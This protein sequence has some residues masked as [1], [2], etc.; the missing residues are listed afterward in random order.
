MS[1]TPVLAVGRRALLQTLVGG[2]GLG[3]ALPS[4]GES[5]PM[6]EHLH[7]QARVSAADAK[8]KTAAWKPA[9]L[10][11]HQVETVTILAE[12][13]VPGSTKAKS[14]QFIDAL[15]SV[16]TEQRQR[17]FLQALGAFEGMA[18]AHAQK[19]WKSLTEADR[20]TLLT[21]A[22]T[23]E[24]GVRRSGRTWRRASRFRR[25]RGHAAGGTGDHDS[26]S[27]R[28]PQGLDLRRVLL[29]RDGH[30]RAGVDRQRL[31][32]EVHRVPTRGLALRGRRL[33]MPRGAL[34]RRTLAPRSSLRGQPP[35]ASPAAA[36]VFTNVT[37]AAGITFTHVNGAFGKKY[38]P[39]TMGSGVAFLDVD[40]DG[41]QDLF[42]VN[43]KSWPGQTAFDDRR[44][45]SIATTATARS[46]TSRNKRGSRSRCTAS[47][48]PPRISTTTATSIC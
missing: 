17:R 21:K 7:D 20:T 10:D 30:A 22:S 41:Y 31:L 6:H 3:L 39:E 19:P 46:P 45:R 23:A 1:D 14:A 13:I 4:L 26:R 43:G 29:V 12:Q 16:D 40:G 35:A 42:F 36:V 9:F 32:R 44:R 48:R 25:W 34:S 2:A 27:V 5:H 15:L 18:I 8:A 33:A 28:S 37:A 38:L 47:A 11:A 24:P